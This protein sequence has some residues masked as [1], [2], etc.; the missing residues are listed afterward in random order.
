[1]VAKIDSAWAGVARKT[2]TGDFREWI[3]DPEE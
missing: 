2:G 1:M 3:S